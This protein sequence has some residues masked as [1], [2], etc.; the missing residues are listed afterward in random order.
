MIASGDG[1]RT[2]EVRQAMLA[3]GSGYDS[4]SLTGYSRLTPEGSERTFGPYAPRSNGYT[5]TR[6]SGR[7]IRVRLTATKDEEWSVGKMRLDVA[8]GTG[9]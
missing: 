3:S 6:I 4:M 1:D 8:S 7:D 9:R 5:D 2:L